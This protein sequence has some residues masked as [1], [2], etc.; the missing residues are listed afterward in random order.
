MN[1]TITFGG[2]IGRA[3]DDDASPDVAAD[4]LAL[5]IEPPTWFEGQ[6]LVVV[7]VTVALGQ[8]RHAW[9]LDPI[10]AVELWIDAPELGLFAAFP[11]VD[12]TILPL[13]PPVANFQGP[14]GWGNPAI[15][16]RSYA[17]LQLDLQLGDPELPPGVPE[18]FAIHLRA[19]L[20]D[21][22]SNQIVIQP[23]SATITGAVVGGLEV[24]DEDGGDDALGDE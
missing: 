11:L 1:P 12:P 23:G 16:V 19:T 10:A 14:C 22:E 7:W 15:T 17:E 20:Q 3:H 21:L 18:D 4:G 2:P 5:A 9:F 13:D 24:D 8:D 6:L